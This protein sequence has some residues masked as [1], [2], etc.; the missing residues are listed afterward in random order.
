MREEIKKREEKWREMRRL[1]GKEI[2]ALERMVKKLEN[3]MRRR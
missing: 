2:K 1:M 3:N